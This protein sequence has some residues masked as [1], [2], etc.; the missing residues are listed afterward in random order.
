MA[1]PVAGTGLSEVSMKD[2]NSVKMAK[3]SCPTPWLGVQRGYLVDWVTQQWV[4]HTGRLVDLS[5]E[6]WLRGPSGDTCSVGA[7][8][9]TNL[10]G[11]SDLDIRISA[12]GCGLTTGFD[13]LHSEDFDP[14]HVHSKVRHFYENT[15][16]YHL[17]LWSQ[18]CGLFSPFGWLIAFI[19]SRRLQQLNLPISPLESSRGVTSELVQFIDRQT[20]EVQATGWLR[21]FVATGE[22]IYAGI[23]SSG[24]P[25]RFPGQCV[26]VVFPLPNGSAMVFL[27]PVA[28]KDGSFSLVSHGH[29]FGD[30]GFYF[31]VQKDVNAAWVKYVRA[32][33]ETIHVYL[34]TKDELHADHVLK[35]WGLTFLNLHYRMTPINDPRITKTHG[36]DHS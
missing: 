28:H 30:P 8:Y 25:C 17:D 12:E 6:P 10:A 9:F 23:Y 5:S 27:K 16:N 14:A 29:S 31:L 15:S 2:N 19:F 11:R 36:P 33:H 3:P 32:M 21:K 34:D 18:W 35:L 4:R 22:V 24:Q 20:R 13:Y 26:K 1:Q 7:E